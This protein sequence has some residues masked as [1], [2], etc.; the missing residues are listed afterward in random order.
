ML[1]RA[2]YNGRCSSS[3]SKQSRLAS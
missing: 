1:G 3:D 2:R